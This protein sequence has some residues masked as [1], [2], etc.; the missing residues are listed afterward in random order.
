MMKTFSAIFENGVFRPVEP[1]DFPE[2]CQVRVDVRSVEPTGESSRDEVSANTPMPQRV[3]LVGRLAMIPA[4][5]HAFDLVLDDGRQAGVEL[6][7]GDT[8][9]VSRLIGERVLVLGTAMYGPSGNLLRIDADEV[10]LSGD[11]GRFF[12]AAPRLARERLDVDE[13]LHEQRHKRGVSAIL[14]QWPGDE[15]DDEIAAALKE[16][17]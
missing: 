2:H 13:V 12:S 1:V 3:R 14:G 15:S 4:G 8:A 16:L 9:V 17:S 7:A 11:D 6:V 5:T 10:N